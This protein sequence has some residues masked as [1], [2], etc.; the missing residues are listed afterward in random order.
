MALL[1]F[2]WWGTIFTIITAL[3][4][5][6]YKWS[7]ISVALRMIPNGVLA[8]AISFSGP[9]SNRISPKYV[10][11]FAQGLLVVA[12]VLLATADSPSKYYSH[13]LPAFI[14]GS[15]GAMLS[16]AHT[17]I[18]I[19]RTS[20]SSMAG[21]VGAIIN[22]ALQLGTAVGIAAVSSIESSIEE[23]SGNPASYAGRAATFWFLLALIG[24]EII[25]LLIFYR[26]EAEHS[27]PTND[28]EASKAEV[29][30][31][32][33]KIDGTSITELIE[34]DQKIFSEKV[35]DVREEACRSEDAERCSDEKRVRE[36]IRKEPVKQA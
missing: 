25:S 10:L 15:A 3:W 20:P 33:S 14:L 6:I 31:V 17:N 18:A 32:E 29:K 5:E 8:F 13:V 2:F 35:D 9:L 21:T 24:L 27:P 22:C 4:Q 16:Y 19:F 26:V 11:L 12:T 30:A 34:T 28:V 23:K 7:V 1:P 36:E